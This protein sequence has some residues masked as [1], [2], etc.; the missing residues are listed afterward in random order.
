M[1]SIKND[2]EVTRM[3]ASMGDYSEKWVS[4]KKILQTVNL[5][6]QKKKIKKK[7]I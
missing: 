1:G 2:Y 4:M 5:L 3:S 6:D 7:I